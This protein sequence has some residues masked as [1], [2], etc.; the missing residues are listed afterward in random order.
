MKILS[1]GGLNLQQ[2]T[3]NLGLCHA[4]LTDLIFHISL[5]PP[6]PARKWNVRVRSVS[7]SIKYQ[8]GKLSTRHLKGR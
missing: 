3:P 4:V 5:P 6:F 8:I 2:A 1:A 7:P